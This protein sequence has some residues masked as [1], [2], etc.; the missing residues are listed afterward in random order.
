MPLELNAEKLKK[1]FETEKLLNEIRDTDVLL[2]RILTEARA[3]ANADA[4]SIYVIEDKQ[5]STTPSATYADEENAFK[6]KTLF[7]RLAGIKDFLPLPYQKRQFIFHSHT[8]KR[9]NIPLLI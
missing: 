1:V 6:D 5:P 4:G 7:V 8:S 3:I 9:V 2:E